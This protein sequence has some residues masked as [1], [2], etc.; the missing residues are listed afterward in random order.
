MDRQIRCCVCGFW[1]T[2]NEYGGLIRGEY[3]D[4]TNKRCGNIIMDVC[5]E[6]LEKILKYTG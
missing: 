2:H 1:I 6:C 5:N 3:S 4:F